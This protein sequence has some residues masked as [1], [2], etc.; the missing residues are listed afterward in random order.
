MSMPEGFDFSFRP[1]G[2]IIVDSENHD[3][4]VST[5]YDLKI[6]LAY[7]RVKS[8]THDWFV[9]NIGANLEELIGRPCN[10]TN[11]EIGKNKIVDSL[12]FDGLWDR[13]DVFVSSKIENNTKVIYSIFLK[14]YETINADDIFVNEES[15][16]LADDPVAYEI[17]AELDL[18][19]GVYIR[20]GWRPRRIGSFAGIDYKAGPRPIIPYREG[21]A[22]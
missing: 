14:I 16:V 9:D 2:D 21:G 11:V 1:E 3:I 10:R 22:T 15:S 7:N 19:K 12:T 17:T 4:Q 20:Y 5:E 6:A 13:D 8:I 18:V